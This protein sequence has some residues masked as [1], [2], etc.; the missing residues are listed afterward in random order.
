M[1]SPACQMR[2]APENALCL[3]TIMSTH[4]L[5]TAPSLEQLKACAAF[6]QQGLL[7]SERHSTTPEYRRVTLCPICTLIPASVLVSAIRLA[8]NEFPKHLFLTDCRD[9]LVD[10]MWVL[11][12]LPTDDDE[13]KIWPDLR[14]A[15]N[16]CHEQ[17]SRADYSDEELFS[18]FTTALAAMVVHC[19]RLAAKNP[20]LSWLTRF[21]T[22]GAWP[23]S[24]SDILPSNSPRLAMLNLLHYWARHSK[25]PIYTRTLVAVLFQIPSIP[26]EISAA[27]MEA[28]QVFV[29]AYCERFAALGRDL[30]R[31]PANS[32]EFGEARRNLG[33]LVAL[34]AA[35]LQALLMAKISPYEFV[36]GYEDQLN[37]ALNEA[38]RGESFLLKPPDITIA[39][40]RV[41]LLANH[42]VPSPSDKLAAN[43]QAMNT[44]SR[45]LRPG[46][47]PCTR[48]YS[49]AIVSSRESRCWARGC[50]R[51]GEQGTS[52]LMRCS[53]C[54]A[55]QYCS[56]EC[57]RAHWKDEIRPHKAV[58]ATLTRINN[59]YPFYTG[60]PNAQAFSVACRSAGIQV[61][62][63]LWPYHHFL[64]IIMVHEKSDAEGIE[65]VFVS[66]DCNHV[67]IWLFTSARRLLDPPPE[68][69]TGEHSSET[70][71]TVP[72]FSFDP[73]I[74]A[75]AVARSR[76]ANDKV[77]ESPARIS[78]GIL[79]LY[80]LG[81]SLCGSV[82]ISSLPEI[83]AM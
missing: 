20:S 81:E 75:F 27:L 34:T 49:I 30:Q 67:L 52:K 66:L 54:R 40:V 8:Q 45:R 74:K 70:G 18:L 3:P 60:E 4:P 50:H 43:V 73:P 21:R 46:Q 61:E 47:D 55:F 42:H 51:Y 56:R 9:F 10:A 25:E 35:V 39:G 2:L 38:V 33:S 72:Q 78:R 83:K 80:L 36:G 16:M 65:S 53:R 31:L 24:I 12:S 22:K 13:R 57:Q 32:P 69:A 82:I 37:A 58:C 7:E 59:A 68:W 26:D 71:V 63:L 29:P 23:A 17:N 19:F 14:R 5:D 62:E 44:F 77:Q 76:T 11:T 1:L 79:V 6:L 64:S 41:L 15:Y 48:F 28:R